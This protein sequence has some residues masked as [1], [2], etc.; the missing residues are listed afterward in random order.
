MDDCG[1]DDSDLVE[2]SWY[3]VTF[4]DCCVAG[5]FTDRFVR[6]DRVSPEDARHPG[7]IGEIEKLVFERITLTCW[8]RLEIRVVDGVDR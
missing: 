4:D 3:E 5:S 6:H 2:G 1:V 8:P 7:D